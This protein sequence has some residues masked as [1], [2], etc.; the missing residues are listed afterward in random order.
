MN[1]SAP[2][3]VMAVVLG[4]MGGL[5]L[6]LFGMTRISESLEEMGGDRVKNWLARCTANR[7]MGFGAGIVAT[8]VLDSSSLVMVLLIALV[9]AR[10]MRF[11][12]CLAVVLGA[13]IGTTASSQIFALDVGHYAPI[14][15]MGGLIV[16]LAAKGERVRR[17]GR[18]VFDFGLLFFGLQQMGAA[19]VPLRGSE[20]FLAWMQRMEGPVAGALAGG[21][22]TA[23]IQSSSA[24]LGILIKLA[25]NGLITL[26]AGIAMMMGAEIGTC[27]TSLIAAIG[28]S[29]TAVRLAAYHVAFNVLSVI[30]GL[31]FFTP[32]VRLVA[33][34]APS[35]GVE[36]QLANGHVLFNTIGAVVALMF[37]GIAADLLRWAI[38]DPQREAPAGAVAAPSSL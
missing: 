3:D 35:A 36:H 26:P 25:A 12:Q 5:A 38:P 2:I 20:T 19:T 14:A 7:F 8:T 17:I 23:I 32:F 34:L 24:T 9:D 18:L 21:L 29:R 22:F 33:S 10:L 27:G 15:L 1:A 4:L 31:I 28:R 30:V 37:T 11:E 16:R 6:F 13:N